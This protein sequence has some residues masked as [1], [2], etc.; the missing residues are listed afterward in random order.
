[1]E[2]NRWAICINLDN[3]KEFDDLTSKEE[4]VLQSGTDYNNPLSLQD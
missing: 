2:S 1:M 4:I 3:L